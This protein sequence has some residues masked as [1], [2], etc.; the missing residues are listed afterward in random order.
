MISLSRHSSTS[1]NSTTAVATLQK[2]GWRI[3]RRG[4]GLMLLLFALL[5]LYKGVQ[6]GRQ[7]WAAY[8]AGQELRHL[9]ATG[10]RLETLPRIQPA[11]QKLATALT[12]LESE[13]R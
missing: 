4:L 7:G 9:A 1:S 6:I 10:L 3:W 12:N 11:V 2:T 13:S 5:V 8:R